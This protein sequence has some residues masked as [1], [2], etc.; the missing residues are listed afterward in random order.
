M[1]LLLNCLIIFTI[2]SLFIIP[3]N[4]TIMLHNYSLAAS[5]I[6]FITSI[7][8]LQIPLSTS[9]YINTNSFVLMS[10]PSFVITY[11]YMLDFISVI[12]IILSTFLGCLVVLITRVIEYR[13]K[14][15][16]ILLFFVLLLLVNCF[17][18]L[19]ILNFYLFFEALLIPVFALIG[20]WGSQIAKIFAANQ[21]FLYTLFGSFFMLTGIVMII[22]LTGTT[23]ILVIKGYLFEDHIE[24]ILF[25]LFFIGLSIKI[26]MIPFHLW[27]PKA[28]VEAPTTGSVL[29][30]GI[31]LKLGSYGFIRFSLFLFPNASFYFLPLILSVAVISIILASF[32]VL[33]QNDLK[34]IIAY[35]SIAHMNFL[36]GAIFVKDLLALTGSLLLQIAH[37]LSSSALFLAIGMLYDRYKSRNIFYYRGLV[38]VMPIFCFFFFI[39]SLA[40]LGFPSTVNF[41][42]EMLIFFG[43]FQTVPSIAI[44]TLTGIFLSAAYSFVLLTR[45]AF[46]PA[47]PFLSVYYDLTRREFYIL[48]PLAFLIIFLGLFP[49]YLTSYWTFGL[50]T[51]FN[52]T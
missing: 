4:K 41:I 31:L 19:E 15:K 40:N 13:L 10:F 11:S 52:I 3:A 7:G 6:I 42:S 49:T 17:S 50:V 18:T 22:I 37:G 23:N 29:L 39:F 48:L 46:G 33:R 25:L 8:L 35:S 45:I 51:W 30:A 9:I 47:S 27:L 36:V 16:Y 20:I 21:F 44:L 24:K 26:P 32:T 12:Y 5:F 43:L 28:H 1:T 14:E 38:T 2:I 34:R